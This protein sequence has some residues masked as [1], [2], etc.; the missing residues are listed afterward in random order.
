M[1]LTGFQAHI[2]RLLAVNRSEDSYLAGGA[3]IL[4][5]P[6]RSGPGRFRYRSDRGRCQRLARQFRP[7]L[8]AVAADSRSR[9][10][11]TKPIAN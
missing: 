6:A 10:S 8:A 7:P 2:G 5:A 9:R 1:P 11:N 3:A 4:A